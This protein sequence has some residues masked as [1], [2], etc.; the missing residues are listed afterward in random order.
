M[1][2]PNQLGDLP[3]LVLKSREQKLTALT[4]EAEHLKNQ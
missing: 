4:A 1:T 3:S 2:D